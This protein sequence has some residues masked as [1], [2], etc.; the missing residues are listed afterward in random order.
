MKY[1]TNCGAELREGESFC[2]HCGQRVSVTESVKKPVYTEAEFELE[3]DEEES[4]AQENPAVE[5]RR[6]EPQK[7]TEPVQPKEPRFTGNANVSAQSSSFQAAQKPEPAPKK[8]ISGLSIAAFICSLTI[9]LSGL[10]IILAIVDLVKSRNQ[11]RKKGLSVA[12]LVI[13]GIV[14]LLAFIGNNIDLETLLAPKE[15]TLAEIRGGTLYA[16]D[17]FTV[18]IGN[19]NWEGEKKQGNHLVF[20][21][22]AEKGAEGG[23]STHIEV[24][25]SYLA[26]TNTKT[27]EAL[28]EADIGFYGKSAKAKS[29]TVNGGY[30]G[31]WAE[32]EK[33]DRRTRIAWWS[34]EDRR[35]TVAYYGVGLDSDGE[36]VY[37]EILDS[38]V[39]KAIEAASP[40]ALQ[41][42][43]DAPKQTN[44][45]VLDRTLVYSPA[46]EF[47]FAFTLK[48]LGWKAVFYDD[49]I[50]VE[51]T[52]DNK[53][54]MGSILLTTIPIAQLSAQEQNPDVLVTDFMESL[55]PSSA[56][57]LKIS[58]FGVNG[59]YF[60]SLADGWAENGWVEV[61]VWMAG[62][63]AYLL[64]LVDSE[65]HGDAE[66]VFYG[67]LSSFRL[68]SEV[69]PQAAVQA[70]AA[71]KKAVN[72]EASLHY[73]YFFLVLLR[74]DGTVT[75]KAD[76]YF[77]ANDFHDLSS[78]TDIV[79][80][81]IGQTYP[82]VLGL[83]SDG[84]VCISI[85]SRDKE[86][87]FGP[88]T[89]AFEKE[90]QSWRD[91]VSIE[92]GDYTVY[93][94]NKNGKVVF[95][96]FNPER[97]NQWREGINEKTLQWNN[98]VQVK[99]FKFDVY[100][101]TKDGSCVSTEKYPREELGQPSDA[102]DL[103]GDDSLE[104]M[105]LS[106]GKVKLYQVDANN[107]YYGSLLEH[108]DSNWKA[109][110]FSQLPT[111]LSSWSNIKKVLVFSYGDHIIG[112]KKD[113]T[114]VSV[115]NPD[116]KDGNQHGQCNVADWKDVIDI[117][118]DN[119]V[120]FGL[121]AD[122]TIICAGLVGTWYDSNEWR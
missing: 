41:E 18:S 98:I 35:F 66:S 94:V 17:G 61:A 64:A 44:A 109:H 113:G 46:N 16:A 27:P 49:G 103:S 82:Y 24:A 45:P 29:L 32:T 100:G 56:N 86:N 111:I 23:P 77:Y 15:Q 84:T 28:V 14:M 52:D 90:L 13:G 106:N 114:L 30:K 102:V 55:A 115:F 22:A 87:Y 79:A 7:Q 96:C 121:K 92:A 9:L 104:I 6:F 40:Q 21:P 31:A 65:M 97:Q 117:T 19:H 76:S 42:A 70:T 95:A 118:G 71:P 43:S 73:G 116:N 68:A 59:G 54:Q 122:G 2:P 34:V 33:G 12:A 80:I 10:G 4:F 99:Q 107:Q 74:E 37:R 39:P 83:K 48:D 11:P 91:I 20:Y 81:D 58:K 5:E 8:K 120:T 57:D 88:S 112:L 26:S 25:E 3:E 89:T 93:G 108:V 105:T 50:T 69:A 78:W 36:A 51:P 75:V 72:Q 67:I 63:R 60:A 110:P 119:L 1:C 38:F 85:P 47:D 101:R 62:E 53:G